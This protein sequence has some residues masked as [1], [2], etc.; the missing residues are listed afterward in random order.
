MIFCRILGEEEV[1]EEEDDL[2]EVGD[3]MMMSILAIARGKR[4]GL[5]VEIP[6]HLN[7]CKSCW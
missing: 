2:G 7:M 4:V 3:L 1:K 5:V 6:E